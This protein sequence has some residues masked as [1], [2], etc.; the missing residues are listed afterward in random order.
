[1]AFYYLLFLVT[2]KLMLY[3]EVVVRMIGVLVQ[4]AV[5][6]KQVNFIYLLQVLVPLLVQEGRFVVFIGPNVVPVVIALPLIRVTPAQVVVPPVESVVIS[7]GLM[8]AD[9]LV[10]PDVLL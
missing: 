9:P 4:R 5:N 3:V 2:A 1:L 8:V 10:I 6:Y 7:A